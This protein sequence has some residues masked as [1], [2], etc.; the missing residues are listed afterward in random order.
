MHQS[1]LGGNGKLVSSAFMFMF[2]VVARRVAEYINRSI[3]RAFGTPLFQLKL[4]AIFVALCCP[5]CNT[6]MRKKYCMSSILYL[7]QQP[8]GIVSLRMYM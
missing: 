6:D 1:V 5:V 2:S 3:Q 8:K 4:S 7:D